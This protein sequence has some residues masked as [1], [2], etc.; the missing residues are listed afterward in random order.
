MIA[1]ILSRVLFWMPLIIMCS[2]FQP[3]SIIHICTCSSDSLLPALAHVV[4]QTLSI[5]FL[6]MS[7]SYLPVNIQQPHHLFHEAFPHRALWKL[8][9]LPIAFHSILSVYFL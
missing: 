4:S 3:S 1:V 8:S 9:P 6:Y 2:I 5:Y 7:Q